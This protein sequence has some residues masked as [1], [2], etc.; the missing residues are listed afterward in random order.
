[1]ATHKALRTTSN[2]PGLDRLAAQLMFQL[3]DATDECDA[4]YPVQECESCRRIEQ[5]KAA[6]LAAIEEEK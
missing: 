3:W 4:Q 1:M 2:A 5:A 6:L